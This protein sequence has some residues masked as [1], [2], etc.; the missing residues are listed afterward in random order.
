LI[1]SGAKVTQRAR[2]AKMAGKR[3]RKKCREQQCRR[4]SWAPARA[5]ELARAA[6]LVWR[7]SRSYQYRGHVKSKAT[8]KRVPLK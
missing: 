7:I 4:A 8:L 1:F 5:R 3:G 6:N 2:V